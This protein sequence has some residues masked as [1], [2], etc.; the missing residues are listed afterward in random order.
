[1]QNFDLCIQD[2]D[3]TIELDASFVKVSTIFLNLFDGLIIQSY[4]RKGRAFITLA[5][6]DQAIES[7]TNGQKKEKD[8]EEIKAM[9]IEVDNEIKLDNVVPKTN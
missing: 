1:M 8:N 9:L 4:I 6:Y 3:K 2:C 7:L 5:K